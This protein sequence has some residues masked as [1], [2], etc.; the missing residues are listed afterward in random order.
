M[1]PEQEYQK[2]FEHSKINIYVPVNT[3]TYH[4][5]R[6]LEATKQSM[7][8]ASGATEDVINQHLQAIIDLCNQK[9][10]IKNIR[11]DIASVATALQARTKRPLDAHCAIRLGATLSFAALV[12]DGVETTLEDPN[13]TQLF[14]LNKKMELAFEIPELYT[15][16]LSMGISSIPQYNDLSSTLSDMDYFVNRMRELEAMLPKE[17]S[18]LSRI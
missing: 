10:E 18:R 13:K 14:W 1:F 11:T 12:K 6:V 8:A 2:V 16:F 17:L 9:G 15:F 7:Y 5:S 3:T 4:T